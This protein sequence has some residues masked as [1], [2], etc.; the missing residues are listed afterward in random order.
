MLWLLQSIIISSSVR[1]LH[2]FRA[3]FRFNI[4]FN[5]RLPYEIINA[6]FLRNGQTIIWTL[7][8]C[9]HSEIIYLWFHLWWKCAKFAYQISLEDSSNVVY[10]KMFNQNSRDKRF[11]LLAQVI[12]CS[13]AHNCVGKRYKN[14]RQKM[15]AEQATNYLPSSRRIKQTKGA[16]DDVI[17][18]FVCCCCGCRRQSLIQNSFL[19]CCWFVACSSNASSKPN[20]SKTWMLWKGFLF[21]LFVLLFELALKRS[22]SYSR[23]SCIW[24][25]RKTVR[26]TKT[27]IE[28]IFHANKW[29][30]FRS[31]YLYDL[32][33]KISFVSNIYCYCDRDLLTALIHS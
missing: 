19:L 9:L 11:Y 28:A 22:F 23:K 10:S 20:R 13:Y 16:D 14:E 32:P 1:F 33:F 25:H 15:A 2:A 27:E 18:I 26:Q 7:K 31:K 12:L 4:G 6:F 24:I 30:Q 29:M 17:A 5:F 8:I 3:Y 21:V